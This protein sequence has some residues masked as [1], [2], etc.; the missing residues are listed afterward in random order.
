MDS[1]LVTGGSGTLGH[2]VVRHLLDAGAAVRVLSRRHRPDSPGG[3][4]WV[5]GDLC[6]GAGLERAVRGASAIVHCATDVRRPHRDIEGTRNLLEATRAAGSAHLVYVSIV[7]VDRVPLP[8]YRTKREA[9]RLVETSGL[10]WTILRS[11]QFHDLLAALLRA[12][13]RLP[14]MV[15]PAGTSFQPVDVSEVAVRLVTLALAPP[16]GRVADLG[17]PE[18]RPATD[19]ARTW[20]RAAGRRRRVVAVPLPGRIAR[21]YRTGHH[22]TPGHAD[23]RRSFDDFLAERAG[24]V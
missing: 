11:T 15:V 10:P 21:G 18:V 9:E 23:G 6:T 3:A 17:G 12:S 22:L 13:A 1:V 5:T 2:V 7:G 16:A 14:V 20:L 19:L 4:Q 8:Y 24:R